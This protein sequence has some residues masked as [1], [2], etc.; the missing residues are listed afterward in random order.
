MRIADRLRKRAG[1]IV[2]EA[3][4]GMSLFLLLMC[5]AIS[6]ITAVNAELYMQRAS[7]NVVAELNVA[8]PFATSG[9]KCIDDV[10]G[11]FGLADNI[12]ID[13]KNLDETLGV[14]GSLSGASGIDLEDVVSTAVFGRYVRDRILTEY[15]S[16]VNDEWVYENLVQNVSVYLDYESGDRSV[17]LYV[18]YDIYAGPVSIPRSYCTSLALYSEVIPLRT[19]DTDAEEKSSSVWDLDNFER[20]S[21]IREKYGGNLPYNFPVI[22]IYDGKDVVSI[23]SMDT[24]SPYYADKNHVQKKLK[25]YIRDLESFDGADYSGTIVTLSAGS[26][27]TLLLVIPENGPESGEQYIH[28]MKNYAEER[29]INIRVERFE[30]SYHYLDDKTNDE[31]EDQ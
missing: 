29:G 18:Y 6:S 25:S 13:T 21:T 14:F 20:G 24:T 26:K 7:E 28:E 19:D 5:A 4:I 15:H 23:K 1:S 11:T 12:S 16:L 17:Y 3:S 2:L 27:K 9:I 31:N 8:I 22:S 10:V 30:K